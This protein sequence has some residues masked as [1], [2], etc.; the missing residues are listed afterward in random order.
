MA[1]A[2]RFLVIPSILVSQL[3]FAEVNHLSR[4]DQR[5]TEAQ[6]LVDKLS[7]TPQFHHE[8]STNKGYPAQSLQLEYGGIP[9]TSGEKQKAIR[10]YRGEKGRSSG[11]MD[12]VA[13]QAGKARTLIAAKKACEKLVP[14]GH[15]RLATVPQVMAFFIELAQSF[16]LPQNPQKKG[17]LFWASSGDE[18][19]DKG[20][21]ETFLSAW[22]GADS[23]IE[24]HE[25]ATFITKVRT[26]I[27]RAKS[28][29]EK[30]YYIEM[31]KK[32]REGIPAVCVIGNEP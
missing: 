11:D 5:R 27:A 14:L 15:W 26:T 2:F 18:V 9:D 12:L 23:Q 16:P 31:L 24:T 28:K 29:E 19:K 25:F 6:S 22:E 21:K 1:K 7:F 17:V 13:M 10:I 8:L 32:T 20:N 3:V 4:A 30:D